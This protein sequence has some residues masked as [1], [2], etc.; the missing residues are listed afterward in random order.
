[1]YKDLFHIFGYTVQSHAVMSVIAIFL[2]FGVALT[3]M[4]KTTYYEHIYKSIF[5]AIIGAIIG[6]RL[7]HVFVFHW[8][9]YMQH[10]GQIVAI[11][12]G[13]ISVLG[14]IVGGS[15]ALIIYCLKHRLDF[16]DLGDYLS[17][18][19]ML[20]MGVGRIACFLTGDAFG[21]PTGREFGITYPK[22]TIAYNTYGDQPLWPVISWEIQADFV[23]FAILL[24]LFGKRLPKGFLF[25]VYL[26]LYGTVR[27]F[28]EF[29]RGDSERFALNLTGGQ[30]TSL[31]FI[32]VGLVLGIWVSIRGLKKPVHKALIGDFQR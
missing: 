20:G 5:W 32:I 13:G 27:F 30:W 19:M 21:R 31:G 14:A 1:M 26:L 29:F 7:W 10:P 6:A 16:L 8:P 18:A 3:L 11:W 9:Y 25:F 12:Q 15:V 17:P 4:R 22:G 28:L 2:G 23:V 24:Y